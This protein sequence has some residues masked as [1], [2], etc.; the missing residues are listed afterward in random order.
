[1]CKALQVYIRVKIP[2]ELFGVVMPSSPTPVVFLVG[3]G[4]GV[5]SEVLNLLAGEGCAS[6]ICENNL[7]W[8]VHDSIA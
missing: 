4:R 7:A 5:T 1:M 3:G 8:W 6:M 2:R